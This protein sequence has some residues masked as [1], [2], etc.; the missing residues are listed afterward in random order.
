[1]WKGIEG[2]KFLLWLAAK[3]FKVAAIAVT[4]LL[5]SPREKFVKVTLCAGNDL[6]D[7]KHLLTNLEDYARSERCAFIRM[8]G[9]RG[10]RRMFLDYEEPWITLQKRL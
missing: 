1:M 3:E 10:W 6:G 5:D 4:E 7:W 2:G 8:E 9:R